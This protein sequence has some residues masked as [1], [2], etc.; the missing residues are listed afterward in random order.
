ML[1]ALFHFCKSLITYHICEL[2]YTMED[3]F[4]ELLSPESV[5][6]VSVTE[7]LEGGEEQ[8]TNRSLLMPC[9]S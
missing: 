9:F 7:L 1:T 2:Q 6:L 4:V 5:I 8:G 3:A